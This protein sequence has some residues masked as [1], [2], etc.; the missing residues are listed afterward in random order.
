MI[1]ALAATIAALS[2]AMGGLYLWQDARYQRAQAQCAEQ[3]AETAAMHDAELDSLRRAQAEQF[4]QERKRRQE[5]DQE[6]A[7]HEQA[8]ITAERRSRNL[9]Q[10]LAALEPAE[11]VVPADRVRILSRAARGVRDGAA[12]PAAGQPADTVPAAAAAGD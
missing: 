3:L 2:V 8:R 7:Q 11:C 10:E 4:E 1:Q 12:R 5:A 9:Q 6:A